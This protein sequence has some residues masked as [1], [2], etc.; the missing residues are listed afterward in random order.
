MVVI[1]AAMSRPLPHGDPTHLGPFQVTARLS[2][3]PAGITFLGVDG[4]GRQVSVA[5]LTRAAAGDAAARDR[6]RA[7]IVGADRDA[8]APVV[9]AEPD[10]PTPWVA[11]VHEPNAPGAE[12]FLDPVLLTGASRGR[13]AGRLRG[14]QFQPYWMGSGSRE[15]AVAAPPSYGPAGDA[16]RPVERGLVAAILMLA[17]LLAVLLL[18]LS[19]LFACQPEP[20]PPSPTFFPS[21]TFEQPTPSPV[22]PTPSPSRTLTGSPTPEPSGVDGDDPGG[23]A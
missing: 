5:V 9:A 18:L 17:A 1:V 7:A 22:E 11:T 6:F 8:T 15:P 4:Q 14:P 13:W 2:E 20:P 3:T 12:R 10:G 19:M 16:D 21:P 23:S